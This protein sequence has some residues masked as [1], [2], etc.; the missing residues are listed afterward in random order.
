MAVVL[1]IAQVGL[2]VRDQVLVVHAAREGAR[3]ASVSGAP[4]EAGPA[5]ARATGLDPARLRVE[6]SMAGN[7]V[8]VTARYRSRVGLPVLRLLVDGVELDATV[9][10]RR[11]GDWV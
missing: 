10:M 11:E 3:A 8:S 9:V 4:G 5:A 1:L 7:A 6:T 2:V